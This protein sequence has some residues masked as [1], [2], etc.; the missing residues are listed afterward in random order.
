MFGHAKRYMMIKQKL[1]TITSFLHQAFVN[2]YWSY[3]VKYWI[4]LKY[5]ISDL[6]KKKENIWKL[7]MIQFDWNEST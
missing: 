3:G 1:I 5:S 7:G 2:N 4:K 6:I